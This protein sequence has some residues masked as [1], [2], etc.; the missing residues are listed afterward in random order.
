MLLAVVD[1]KQSGFKY[2]CLNVSNFIRQIIADRMNSIG[3]REMSRINVPA[4]T[5]GIHTVFRSEKEQNFRSFTAVCFTCDHM[6][7][8]VCVCMHACVCACICL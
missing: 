4:L 5:C 1:F 7:V 2:S 3:K 6:C 8:C